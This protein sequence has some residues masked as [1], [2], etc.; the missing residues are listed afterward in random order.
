MTMQ[1]IPRR[2]IQFQAVRLCCLAIACIVVL[3]GCFFFE[4]AEDYGP[5]LKIENKTTLS[6]RVVYSS[7]GEELHAEDLRPGETAEYV[8]AFITEQTQ[9]LAGDLIA[10]SGTREVARIH[11]PCR[12]TTWT[13]TE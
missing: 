3:S 7:R 11:A 10:R 12:A 1:P 8:S 2:E 13:I 5:R 6:L 4:R 9:C